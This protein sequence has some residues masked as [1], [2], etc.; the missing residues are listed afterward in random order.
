[1]NQPSLVFFQ[2]VRCVN[3]TGLV[4]FTQPVFIPPASGSCVKPA[5]L[6]GFTQLPRAGLALTK[7]VF[8]Q[9]GLIK[10]DGGKPLL[11]TNKKHN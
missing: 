8:T 2:P 4:G 11:A 7:R 1:M 10:G 3:P 9:L 6:V 5:G